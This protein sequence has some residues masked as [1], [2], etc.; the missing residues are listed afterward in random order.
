MI[1]PS[2]FANVSMTATPPP[3][4]API[5]E[6]PLKS[7][8]APFPLVAQL[9]G[10]IA[11]PL[12]VVFCVRLPE[13]IAVAAVVEAATLVPGY[14]QNGSAGVSSVADTIDNPAPSAATQTFASS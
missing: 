11:P 2:S 6:D 13:F 12:S 3:E 4:P 1:G 14:V 5:P 8:S 10:P 9:P 7:A